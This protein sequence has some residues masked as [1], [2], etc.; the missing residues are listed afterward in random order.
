MTRSEGHDVARLELVI[1]RL[2]RIGTAMSSACFAAGLLLVSFEQ[3]ATLA[4]MMLAVGF[5]VL[6]A[7]PVARVIASVVE[8][9]RE[10]DWVFVALTVTVLFALAGSVVAAFWG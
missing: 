3:A 8:Y 2:L 7:T 10:R 6:L 4:R 1:G 5:F 9:V